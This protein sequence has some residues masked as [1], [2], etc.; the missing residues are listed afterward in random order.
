MRRKKKP[1]HLSIIQPMLASVLMATSIPLVT[2][3]ATRTDAD[4][5]AGSPVYQNYN[6]R[7]DQTALFD[8]VALR[9]AHRMRYGS[10]S[11]VANTSSSVS[12]ATSSLPPCAAPEAASTDAE[13]VQ[14]SDSM[15]RYDDLSDTEKAELR[16]QIRIG[17]CPYDVLPGYRQ[18]CELMLKQHRAIHP[19]AVPSADA[20]QNR[21]NMND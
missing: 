6:P 19:A 10:S 18:L 20:E 5:G 12:S 21:F 11:S 17:G 4:V 7:A 2:L 15:L 13:G 9:K 8:Q 16:K 14:S 3:A 1:I